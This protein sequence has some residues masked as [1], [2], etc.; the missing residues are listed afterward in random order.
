MTF[1]NLSLLA[2]CGKCSNSWRSRTG[3]APKKCPKC[4]SMAWNS[5]IR[6]Y[7]SIISRVGTEDP[8]THYR[9]FAI[10]DYV[11]NPA[12][13]S[14]DVF[15]IKESDINTYFARARFPPGSA[16]ILIGNLEIGEDKLLVINELKLVYIHAAMYLSYNS[17]VSCAYNI[18]S[19]YERQKA[20][21]KQEENKLL[22][23]QQEDKRKEEAIKAARAR[24]NTEREKKKQIEEAERII[25]DESISNNKRMEAVNLLRK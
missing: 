19:F 7:T 5:G 20:L 4:G 23:E 9:A 22:K 6:K 2:T 16:V 14:D 18:R 1:D 24:I 10:I 3:E 21:K 25:N 13:T 15:Y 12:V 11:D 17:Q 8:K